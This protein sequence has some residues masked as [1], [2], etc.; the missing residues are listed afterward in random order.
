VKN[1]RR[2]SHDSAQA[3][4]HRDVQA[5][6]RDEVADAG[7]VEYVP[8]PLVDTALVTDHQRDDHACIRLAL[9]NCQDA[10]TQPAARPL[11]GVTG[12]RRP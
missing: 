5:G 4:Q 2:H 10:A 7:P 6:D 9:Q 1:E 8:R 12:A 11:H 3:R